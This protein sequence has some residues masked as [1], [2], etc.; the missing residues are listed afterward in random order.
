MKISQQM[1]EMLQSIYSTAASCVKLSNNTVSESFPCQK[2]VRQGCNLSPLLFT[3]DLQKE[4][5]KNKSGVELH[6]SV[7]LDL[8][9]YADDIVLISSSAVGL[10]KH[11]YTLQEYSAKE[12]RCEYR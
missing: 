1:L 6:D 9:M 4:L 2:G 3:A 11:L 12:V 5:K 10:R 7:F 8:L